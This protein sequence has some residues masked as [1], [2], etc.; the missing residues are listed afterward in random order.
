MVFVDVAKGDPEFANELPRYLAA[1]WQMFNQFEIAGYVAT[2][3]QRREGTYSRASLP[4]RESRASTRNLKGCFEHPRGSN[5]RISS[6]RSDEEGA[7]IRLRCTRR[8]HYAD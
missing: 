2:E 7:N 8:T 6:G 5:T 1:V 3:S 4:A